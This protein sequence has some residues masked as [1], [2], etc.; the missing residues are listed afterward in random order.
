LS[1]IKIIC[2]NRKAFFNYSFEDRYEAGMVLTGTEVKSLREGKAVLKDSYA[3]F[4]DRELYL[5]N[6]HISP[7]SLGN[8]ENHE[9]TRKRKLLLHRKELDKL[10]ALAET[11]GYYLVPTK[12]YFKKGIAKVEIGVG[13][14]KKTIDKREKIQKRQLDREVERAMKRERK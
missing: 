6:A 8:R 4:K 14:S 13:K 9:P 2:D 3:L 5:L 10:W 1:G 11:R 7:Y 12:L